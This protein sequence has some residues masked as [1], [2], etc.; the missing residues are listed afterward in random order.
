[1]KSY[2]V[3]VGGSDSHVEGGNHALQGGIDAGSVNTASI[4]ESSHNLCAFGTSLGTVEFYD[5]RARRRV[6][7]LPSPPSSSAAYAP[8]DPSDP[9]AT[10]NRTEITALTFAPNGLTF[11]SGT[12]A[13]LTYLYDLRSPRPF[14]KK[15]QGYGYP[16]HT[17]QF[18]PA[19]LTSSAHSTPFTDP[20]ILSSDKRIIK[21][22]SSVTAEP[23]TAVEPAVDLNSIALYPDSGLILTANEGRAQ[24]SFFI[25]SLGPAPRWCSFLDHL[26][27][28]MAEDAADPSVFHPSSTHRSGEVYD[29]YKFLTVPQL[30]AV[31]LEHLIG[32]T[33]LL[34]P[35]MH[36]Y[37]VDQQLYEEARVIS[38]P[39]AWAEQRRK[40]V[41]ERIEKERESRIRGHKSRSKLQPEKFKVNKEL[42][43]RTLEREERHRKRKV[44]RLLRNKEREGKEDEE[45]EQPA[46]N[47]DDKKESGK[48]PA[49]LTDPRFASLFTNEEFAVDETSNEFKALN[50][51]TKLAGE[52]K[53]W[54]KEQERL[55]NETNE[56]GGG[57][58]L[59]AAE[60]EELRTGSGGESSSSSDE[61]ENEE[62]FEQS[63][64]GGQNRRDG[65]QNRSQPQRDRRRNPHEQ[66]RKPRMHVS[67]SGHKPS[68]TRKASQNMSFGAR[69]KEADHGGSFNLRARKSTFGGSKKGEDVRGDKEVP[70]RVGGGDITKPPG[71]WHGGNQTRGGGKRE[72]KGRRS[73]SGNTFRRM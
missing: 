58:K 14:L 51:S 53:Q 21:L 57:N 12:S 9:F 47:R 20:L 73:A 68:D 5:A 52:K 18:L 6:A 34:R 66:A 2:D 45:D 72:W 69:V 50:A 25:P 19:P 56:S 22:W 27:E 42:A 31:N 10:A 16:I 37:F 24:H 54:H 1:M 35:Y 15:D 13:G 39:D 4:A 55:A 38:N 46:E 7:L 30:R 71:G 49:L 48:T 44:E 62:D 3:D 23:F 59:T 26:V 40:S 28:E 60:L 70:F 29:N 11:A 64:R 32:T 67:S 41:R 33:S 43:Q 8:P 63:G 65:L 17:L 36:G 61:G